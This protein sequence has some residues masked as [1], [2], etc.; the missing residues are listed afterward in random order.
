VNTLV[1]TTTGSKIRKGE[2]NSEEQL[3]E[4]TMGEALETLAESFGPH[5]TSL[6]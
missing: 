4:T 5:A 2:F 6:T 1:D 3:S